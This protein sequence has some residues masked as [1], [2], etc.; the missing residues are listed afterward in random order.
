MQKGQTNRVAWGL[1]AILAVP[2]LGGI[3][4]LG[5]RLRPYWVAKYRGKGANLHA[6]MLAF[7][8]LSGADLEGANLQ[9]ANL[10]GAILNDADL[11][12]GCKSQGR[13]AG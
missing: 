11:S 4:W 9:G 2:L 6:A 8:P 13:Y 3:V 7:A 1:A 10:S 12:R 5:V